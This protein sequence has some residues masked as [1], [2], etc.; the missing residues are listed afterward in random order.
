MERRNLVLK[1]IHAAK[2]VL[3]SWP[4]SQLRGILDS[5]DTFATS[6]ATTLPLWPSPFEEALECVL[7]GGA[8]AAAEPALRRIAR[9]ISAGDGTVAGPPAPRAS[10]PRPW[11]GSSSLGTPAAGACM[12]TRPGR[13]PNKVEMGNVDGGPPAFTVIPCLPHGDFFL[14]FILH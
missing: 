3:C 14:F 8:D 4:A 12:C 5:T 11:C 10:P 9:S 6:R 1:G 2:Q 13:K 7:S